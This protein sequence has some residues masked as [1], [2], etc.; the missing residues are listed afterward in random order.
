MSLVPSRRF[1]G[2]LWAL[3]LKAVLGPEGTSHQVVLDAT[4]RRGK[5]IRCEVRVT[6]LLGTGEVPQGVILLMDEVGASS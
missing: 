4:N 5:A 2:R 1:R 6:P 3:A